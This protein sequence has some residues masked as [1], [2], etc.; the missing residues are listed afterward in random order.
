MDAM[1]LPLM[2][3]FEASIVGRG[4]FRFSRANGEGLLQSLMADANGSKV[5]IQDMGRRTSRNCLV[6]TN[7][8]LRNG[9]CPVKSYP[10]KRFQINFSS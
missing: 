3:E 7:V 2:S 1:P 10:Y 5:S 8:T 4:R 6:N 9:R